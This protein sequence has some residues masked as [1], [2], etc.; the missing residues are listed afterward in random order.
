M[1]FWSRWA[2]AGNARADIAASFERAAVETLVGRTLKA[3]KHI[4]AQRIVV[5]GGVGANQR[6]R[7]TLS[8]RFEGRVYYARQ[9]YCT[10]NGAMIA[11]AGAMRLANAEDPET[12]L[13]M[14]RWPLDS[15]RPP[16]HDQA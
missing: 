9:A 13:A 2:C 8:A 7:D 4:D 1:D 16:E 12:I 15:L 11:L 5:A 14:A 3:A 10:D 6:L